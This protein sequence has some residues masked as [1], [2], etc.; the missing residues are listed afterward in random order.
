MI[1]TTSSRISDQL[2]KIY[3]PCTGTVGML[4]QINE[5]FI[6]GKL[7]SSLLSVMF[8]S[9]P[10]HTVNFGVFYLGAT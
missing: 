2:R 4:L 8:L 10:T 7:K 3:S 9:Y 6:I 1:G 5:Q